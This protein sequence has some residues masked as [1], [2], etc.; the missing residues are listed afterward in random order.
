MNRSK[1]LTL[2]AAAA[3][4]LCLSCGYHLAGEGP[5]VLDKEHRELF[6]AEVANPTTE[7]WLGPRL[8]SLLRDELTRRGQIR[9][10]DRGRASALVKLEVTKFSRGSAVYG[11]EEQ[12]LRYEVE[13]RFRARIV[14]AVDN[15][16]LWDSGEI[17][18]TEPYFG[19]EQTAADNTVTEQAV[20]RLAERMS[21]NY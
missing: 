21:E 8:R 4:L 3:A 15:T 16:L 7:T 17:T 1:I 6:I 11:V 12:T 14:S 13:L 9:W 5:L 2:A 19:N 18:Q 10:V 20:R